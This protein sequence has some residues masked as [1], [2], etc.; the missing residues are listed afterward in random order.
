ML[1]RLISFAEK[2]MNEERDE[3]LFAKMEQQISKSEST[4]RGMNE[5]DR[6]WF[7]TMK[8][9]KT[10]RERLDTNFK[11]NEAT[12]SVTSVKTEVGNKRKGGAADLS[13]LS[14]SKRKKKEIAERK[15]STS[16]KHPSQL[17]KRRYIE[18]KEKISLLRAKATKTAQKPKP[19]RSI[20]E[21]VKERRSVK[22][23]HTSKFSVDLTN[24]SRRGTKRLR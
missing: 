12:K 18:S 13:K 2:I 14:E 9:R 23:K 20:E 16:N 22:N 8:Q 6:S 1:K 5:R 3:R 7:Q 15:A 19:V 11:A 24:T 4:L 10:E 21:N 17:A